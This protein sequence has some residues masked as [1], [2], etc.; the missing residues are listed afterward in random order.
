MWFKRALVIF[1]YILIAFVGFELRPVL[2][3]DP[4]P[5][6]WSAKITEFITIHTPKK[7]TFLVPQSCPDYQQVVKL[8][9]SALPMHSYGQQEFYAQSPFDSSNPIDPVIERGVAY[10]EA[11]VVKWRYKSSEPYIA[12]ELAGNW[13]DYFI[14]DGGKGIS[15]Q[16]I[17]DTLPAFRS[18]MEAS[19]FI[20]SESN[21]IPLYRYPEGSFAKKI[22]FIKGD[23]LYHFTI[24]EDDPPYD[25][26]LPKEKL[27]EGYLK[28]IHIAMNCAENS[29]EL[30]SM[31]EQYLSF[32]HDFTGEMSVVYS[33]RKDNLAQFTLYYPGGVTDQTA[34]E[35][36]D[37]RNNPMRLVGK[38]NNF[39]PCVDYERM[40]IG[41]GFACYRPE[42]R[43]FD[44]V[45]Y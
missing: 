28:P 33:G 34:Y 26:A 15:I 22:G 4:I 40:K 8:M 30:R 44:V 23:Y 6:E 11:G 19:G 7:F 24:I 27:P 3:F 42:K 1:S 43:E 31:Y 25:P 10:D 18:K 9:G 16:K 37:I 14:N 5:F 13:T 36:Y 32:P 39:I 12:F 38:A 45:T 35:L 2:F 20:F 41:K 29:K 17:M 21:D